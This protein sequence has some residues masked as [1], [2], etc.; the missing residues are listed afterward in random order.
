M[1]Y[2][3]NGYRIKLLQ[4]LLNA[5]AGVY[6]LAREQG[7]HTVRFLNSTKGKKNVT[8]QTV[9]NV[10]EGYEYGGVQRVGTELERK[11]LARSV[12]GTEME[13][14][15][16]VIVITDQSVRPLYPSRLLRNTADLNS[17]PGRRRVSQRLGIRAQ[18]LY[19]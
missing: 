16:L 9:K 14:P 5:I 2:D 3:Q 11:I 12:L 7:I 19:L 15:M 6:N 1:I 8:V 13:K 10:L 17:P 18:E 4:N